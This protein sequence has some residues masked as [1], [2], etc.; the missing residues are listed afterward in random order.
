MPSITFGSDTQFAGT[1]R[2]YAKA[3]WADA[4]VIEE[5]AVLNSVTISAQPSVPTASFSYRYGPAL[6]RDA[7]T[8]AMRNK[9]NIEGWFIAIEIDTPESIAAGDVSLC[10]QWVGYVDAVAES[11]RGAVFY[12]GALRATGL[13][14]FSC[15][16]IINALAFEQVDRTFFNCN[17]NDPFGRVEIGLSPPIFNRLI[18]DRETDDDDRPEQSRAVAKVAEPPGGPTGKSFLHI[19]E[20]IYGR[21]SDTTTHNPWSTR[22]IAEHLIDRYAPRDFEGESII[23]FRWKSDALA[24][25]PDADRPMLDCAGKNLLQCLDELITASK[26]LGY[27][28]TYVVDASVPWIELSTYTLTETAITTD[29]YTVPANADT[30]DL[31]LF[32][33]PSTSYTTQFNLSQLYNQVIARGAK[34]QV[35]A[36]FLPKDSSVDTTR[37]MQPSWSTTLASDQQTKVTAVSTSIPTADQIEKKLQIYDS[38]QFA[39]VNSHFILRTT[40]AWDFQ[41][42][43]Q[44][45]FEQEKDIEGTDKDYYPS[46]QHLRVLE[47][48]PLLENINYTA[49]FAQS[50]LGVRPRRFL[51]M[52]VF[53][54]EYSITTGAPTVLTPHASNLMYWG[55]RH[56]RT[57]YWTATQPPFSIEA[58]ALT[59]AIGVALKVN[60]ASQY[61]LTTSSVVSSDLVPHLPQ[62]SWTQLRVTLALEEDRRLEQRWPATVTALDAVRRLYIDAPNMQKNRILAGTL[63]WTDDQVYSVPSTTTIRDDTTKLLSIAKRAAAW[64]TKPRKILRV[65]TARTTSEIKLGK[66][67]TTI[68]TGTVQ[69]QTINTVVTQMAF[70]FSDRAPASMEIE[71]QSGQLDPL[72]FL[73]PSWQST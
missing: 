68:E 4:W 11:E 20:K 55:N 7:T 46:P 16:G 63:L 36:T 73:P 48:L 37:H 19:F 66:L 27:Y 60:G 28:A 58:T 14:Q 25:L 24:K 56:K 72:A 29:D 44:R 59:N 32:A 9:V 41:I 12:D 52:Q 33:D 22:D 40:P 70:S 39:A 64:F 17:A 35:V 62:I 71:T 53:S 10:H 2:L 43:S 5:R 51:A 13:Q 49:G 8:W 15:V 65:R 42:G 1:Y 34:R 61:Q 6:E 23:K 31:M 54:P 26:L 50:A 21:A 69:E 47:N 57:Y 45:L 18:T 3:R 30:V 67:I 38:P